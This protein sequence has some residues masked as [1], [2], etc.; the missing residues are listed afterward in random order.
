MSRSRNPRDQTDPA[1]KIAIEL[2]LEHNV[3]HTEMAGCI[4]HFEF[5]IFKVLDFADPI[6]VFERTG[7]PFALVIAA[8]QAALK[9]WGKPE[10]R[11]EERFRLVH[12]LRR[13]GLDKQKVRDL[14]KVMSWMTVLPEELE[15][16]FVEE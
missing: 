1:W 11:Y 12:Q 7:N 16:R 10:L 9:T 15:L 4:R 14:A 5:P 8:H 13:G 6:G 2:F 3:Y